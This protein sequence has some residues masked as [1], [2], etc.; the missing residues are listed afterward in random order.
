VPYSVTYAFTTLDVP[1]SINTEAL[2]INDAGKIVGDYMDANSHTHGFVFSNGVYTTVNV[3]GAFSTSVTAINNTGAIA[4]YYVDGNLSTHG[5]IYSG[6]SYTFLSDPDPN[7]IGD[8]EITGINDAGQV[9]GEW[10]DGTNHHGFLYSN[11]TYTPLNGPSNASAMHPGGINNA[12]EISGTYVDLNFGSPQAGSHGFLDSGGSYVTLNEPLAFGPPFCTFEQGINNA[13]QTVGSYIDSGGNT[14]HGFLY[15]GSNNYITIDD[16]LASSQYAQQANGV[17]DAG[18][19]VG[20]YYDSSGYSH[21][22]LAQVVGPVFTTLDHRAAGINNLGQIVGSYVD[23][24]GVS[25]SYLYSGGTYKTLGQKNI[26][27][28]GINDAGDIV[29]YS[30]TTAG[31]FGFLDKGG[32]LSLLKDPSATGNTYAMGINKTGQIVGYYNNNSGVHG[33]LD[34]GGGYKTLD[35]PNATGVTVATGINAAGQIAGYYYDGSGAHSFLF[36]GGGYTT[37]DDPLATNGTFASGINDAGD[38]VG[39]YYVGSSE[40]GFVYSGGVYTPINDPS[41]SA[42]GHSAAS[43]INNAGQIVGM[44]GKSNPE[45]HGFVTNLVMEDFFTAVES[46]TGDKITGA[47]LDD[48]GK[49]SVGSTYQSG[50]DNA[51]G[52]WTYTVNSVQVAVSPLQSPAYNG[53][54]YDAT[55]YDHDLNTTFN[56]NVGAKGY[57]GISP[58]NVSGKS[59]FGSD[60]DSVTINGKSYKIGYLYVVPD[61]VLAVP[62]PIISQ[63]SAIHHDQS[64]AASSLFT[65]SDPDAI[66]TFGFWDT[67]IGGG[68]F[69]LDGVAQGSDQEIDVTAAQLS[70]L[71]Y[72]SGSG[73]DTLWVRAN[74]STQWSPWSS[75]F[76]VT[77]QAD[78]PPVV[79][80]ANLTAAHGQGFAASSLFAA[81]DPDGDAITQYGFWDT[82]SGGGHFALDGVAQG[83]NQEIDVTATQLSQLSYQS[84]S[85]ADTLW[86]R[87]ND[88]TQWSSWSNSFTVMAP[89]DTPPMVSVSNVMATHG[90]SFAASSLFTA[91]DAD[92]DMITT[93]AFW[94]TGTGGGHFMLNGVA[95]GTNQEIDVAAAQLSQLTYQSGSGADT[96]WVRANDGYQWSAWS[97]SFTVTPPLDTAP[98]VTVA[99][100][101]A[102]HGQSF[103]ASSLF[104]VS[105][106]D[107]DAI[108]QYGF[109]GTGGGHFMLNGIAQGTNQE[110]DVTAAQLS[111]LSYQSGSGSDT[112]WVRANDGTQWG[113]WSSSFTVT[114]PIDTGPV[115]TPTNAN[116]SS[117]ADQTFAVSSLI[118]YSDPFGSPATQYDF[119]NSGGGGGGHFLLNGSALPANQDNI[120][121]GAQLGQ[122][123][124]QVDNGSDTLW[125]KANDGTVWGGWSNSFT[126]SDPPA[127]AAGETITLGSAYAGK[128]DFMS[129]TGTLKLEDTSS[130]AGTVAGLHGQDA[131]DLA[132]FGF[133]ANSTLGYAASADNSGGTLSVGDG[134]HMANIALL[135]SYMASTFVAA[136]DG[137][138]GT[139]ISEAA[140]SSA[141]SPLL[142]QPHG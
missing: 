74:D 19:I 76:T 21:G 59:Y 88:G 109:W 108:T 48:T 127:V 120:I 71:S 37:L 131:I 62:T 126:I 60:S 123:S 1:N 20:F 66:A 102:A 22:Y 79:T 133:G 97:N 13:G 4:G 73:T 110:I 38:I 77:G 94:D 106:P 17:N 118:T 49:Y 100:V 114:A 54:I 47:V 39:H 141:Q 44:F 69:V 140:Q 64:F 43:G 130:F 142:T 124:Y 55:Y 101:T 46:K 119:W 137:H 85:G 112:L 96:L 68:H 41:P 122:L 129:D 51:G 89:I 136:S 138:G 82:G 98:V 80:V 6:G 99:N 30:I 92:G 58:Q 105:D 104:T 8:T 27:A 25:Y 116:L 16:P 113:S 125:A 115:L 23:T 91:S 57:A 139:L 63:L 70:R 12:G 26:V 5:F 86:V 135:G 40:N 7:N 42:V 36:S 14:Y 56:T 32:T 65:A 107:G 67:G 84:G 72:Q 95:K 35:D 53:Y 9:V 10:N 31:T 15:D 78:T 24:Y 111:Q 93:Y 28:T 121:S 11:G 52:T 29:G 87:A 34:S 83:I 61:P 18:D 75:S 2:G 103:A 81:S 132:D 33:F 117:F 134:M 3:P 50:T 90:Q 45:E 128:V